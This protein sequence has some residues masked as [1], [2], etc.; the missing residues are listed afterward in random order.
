MSKRDMR[1]RRLLAAVLLAMS[2]QV[3]YAAPVWAAQPAATTTTETTSAN[4]AAA[5]ATE[6]TDDA[7]EANNGENTD[8]TGSETTEQVAVTPSAARSYSASPM[9]ASNDGGIS[10]YGTETG[11]NTIYGNGADTSGEFVSAF[12]HKAYA[13]GNYSSAFGYY[14]LAEGEGSS[15]FGDEARAKALMSSAFGTKAYAAFDYSVAIGVQSTTTLNEQV[16]FGHKSGDLDINDNAY[17]TNLFRSLVNVKDLELNDTGAITGVKSINGADLKVGPDSMSGDGAKSMAFGVGANYTTASSTDAKHATAFGYNA[18][19]GA[20]SSSAFGYTARATGIASS[21]FGNAAQALGMGSIAFG[22]GAKALVDNS[23]AFGGGT[24]ADAS[25]SSAF[26]YN[27]K[28]TNEYS[29]AIGAKS[30]TSADYQVSFGTW[31]V[32]DAETGAGEWS[33]LRSLDGIKNITLH[34]ETDGTGGA[35]TGVTTINGADLK[36][37]QSTDDKADGYKSMAFG[38]GATYTSTK[39]AKNATAFGAGATATNTNSSA[40]GAGATAVGVNNSVFGAN[41]ATGYTNSS[42]FGVN[43]TANAIGSSAFGALAEATATGSSAFGMSAKTGNTDSVA[44]GSKSTTSADHQVSFGTAKL[45]ATTSEYEWTNLRSLDG[46]KNITLHTETVD[47]VTTGG[48]LNGVTSINDK[49]KFTS[50]GVDFGG[51]WDDSGDKP[52]AIGGQLNG[53]TTI[54]GITFASFESESLTIGQNAFAARASVAIGVDAVADYPNSVAVGREAIASSD[55]SVAIG[56]GATTN[57][58]GTIAIGS[59]ATVGADHA[60]SVAIGTNASTSTA[61][62]VAFGKMTDETTFRSLAGIKDIDLTGAI[63]GLTI[64]SGAL[65]GVTTINGVGI[66][67]SRNLTNVGTINGIDLSSLGGGSVD[68]TDITT[69]I[70]TKASDTVGAAT[71]FSVDNTTGNITTAGTINGVGITSIDTTKEIDLG[72]AWE[73]V[74]NTAIVNGGDYSIANKG[75]LTG[76]TSINGLNFFVNPDGEGGIGIG[77]TVNG[78]GSVGI[79]VGLTNYGDYTAA[80]GYN[81]GAI[82]NYISVFGALS[83]VSKSEYGTVVGYNASVTG[84]DRGTAVGANAVVKNAKNGIALGDQAQVYAVNGTAVGAASHVQAGHTN[85]VAVG[86]GSTTTAENQVNFGYYTLKDDGTAD[87]TSTYQSRNLAGIGDIAMN[88]SLT[89]VSS[90]DGINLTSDASKKEIDLGGTWEWVENDAY[91]SGGDYSATN[92]GSLTGITSINGISFFVNPDGEGGL[93]IG[94]N[95]NGF[96]STGIGIGLTNDG[97]FTA[98][99]G[100]NGTVRGDYNSAFGAVSEVSGN[101]Y[102]TAVGYESQIYNSERGTAVGANSRVGD[103]RDS[104]K[105]ANYGTALGGQAQVYAANGTA[106]GAAAHVQAGHT[107]SVAIG[108]GSTTTAENQVNFGYYTLKDN[109]TADDTSAYQSRNLAGIG[110][111]AM[112]GK[113]TGV[114]DGTADSDAVNF[115]QLSAKADKA[116]TLAG[117]GITDA[118]TKADADTTFAKAD[119]M[120]TALAGKADKATTLAGYGITDA[121]TEAEAKTAIETATVDMATKTK[122]AEDIATATA[123]M[124]TKTQVGT[125]ITT[126]KTELTK[127]FGEAD[128]ALKGELNT[129]ISAKANADASDLSAENQGKWKTALGVSTLEG[130]VSGHT[131]SIGNLESAVNDATSG[132]AATYAK[133]DEIDAAYKAADSALAGRAT[134]LE[135]A[136]TGMTYASDMTTF[137]GGVT[138]NSFTVGTTG[139]GFSASGDMTA[140]TVNGATIT[141]NSFNGVTVE[142]VDGKYKFG[143]IDVTQLNTDV[144]TNKTAIAGKVSQTDFDDIVTKADTG[145][146]AKTAALETTVGGHT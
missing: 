48:E 54:N 39:E 10:T 16:S 142:K 72:G 53:I 92:K 145:L 109:G 130:T 99:V 114:A 37:G 82:G 97:M 116:T 76:I 89:G 81:V 65:T 30:S 125:D 86:A 6:N 1:A 28:A 144:V 105:Y 23:I 24:T 25:Y 45:N 56:D 140:K 40:F 18:R 21:A 38:V 19:A 20:D 50:D 79:G 41:A 33:N 4:D 59:S 61:N 139:F 83:E 47:G 115:K 112:A 49:I 67:A 75:S 108:V 3:W 2:V 117:Y 32:I 143:D 118:Y 146:V 107:N 132:L 14:T 77:E 44:L 78:I 43:A 95:V 35:I 26:G 90:I 101:T 93:G 58:F 71:T 137:A 46:I 124:A 64:S 141:A 80:V 84:S 12:G 68:L 66:D 63:N 60:N 17:K 55:E 121:I 135:T 36:V 13:I 103:Y 113:I 70:A 102:G 122:V 57:A 134:A 133:A 8:A 51:T 123:D 52:V 136:T 106:L 138:A 91:L 127:A 119:A 85:S 128:T 69:T 15:A 104:S 111:I 94:E 100:Y 34:T 11:N 129:A 9:A 87:A 131:T 62:Q 31:K 74:E 120:N 96:G 5:D 73:W 110:D 29:S 22:T 88:G 27:A 7:T 42:A 126:A 98:A